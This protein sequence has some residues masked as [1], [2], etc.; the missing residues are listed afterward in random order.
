M[1]EKIKGIK[2]GKMGWLAVAG[3]GAVLLFIYMKKSLPS[4][5]IPTTPST[6][7]LVNGQITDSGTGLA[8]YGAKVI[9][10]SNGI[11]ITA[12]S[13]KSGHY[14][15]SLGS[16]S[17]GSVTASITGYESIQKPFDLKVSNPSVVNFALVSNSLPVVTPVNTPTITV[18]VFPATITVNVPVLFVRS[19]PKESSALAGS[20]TLQNGDTFIATGWTTGQNVDGENR[21]WISSLGHYVWVG[22][23]D[24]KP[25]PN[26]TP[27]VI[28]SSSNNLPAVSP[29]SAYSPA[30]TAPTSTSASTPAMVIN[31]PSSTPPVSS[32][33]VQI[34][35]S[36]Q[37]HIIDWQT[38]KG[39]NGAT[40]NAGG[41]SAITDSNG[42]YSIQFNGIPSSGSAMAMK[43][44]Y[45]S[46]SSNYVISGKV[47]TL[48]FSLFSASTPLTS[49]PP[50]PPLQNNTQHYAVVAGDTISSIAS[51]FRTTVSNLAALNPQITN[52][53]IIFVG[54][55]ILVPIVSS[56][57]STT[58]APSISTS[59]VGI[60]S[61]PR[62][63]TVSVPSL[64]VRSAPNTTAPLSGSKILYAGDTF[65]ATGYVEGQNVNGENR[66][67]ISSLG[68]YVW[69]GGTEQ[70]P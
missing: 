4:I 33:P 41:Y 10:M 61:Y 56:T 67:W 62:T 21:W 66:W 8:I 26:T 6:G 24:Q 11:S 22:G 23:T 31:P 35:Y 12:S 16:I 49:T 47:T 44:G 53:N 64:Y 50:I 43:T 13:D 32:A 63:V 30:G 5:K 42:F 27:T 57:I 20:N 18:S 17:E 25:D 58:P 14:S 38:G 45:Q 1:E 29:T 52:L 28:S 70:K 34:G 7:A 46:T 2:I 39:I 15:F 40:I 19:A 48:D 60:T 54:Q 69:V 3:A 68:H 65:S 36:L 51:K 55:T 59:S 9:L 37:G